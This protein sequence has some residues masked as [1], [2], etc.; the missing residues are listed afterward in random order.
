[1]STKWAFVVFY[2]QAKRLPHMEASLLCDRNG[3]LYTQQ[4]LL[5]RRISVAASQGYG[6]QAQRAWLDV[7]RGGA[8]SAAGRYSQ[9]GV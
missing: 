1:M 6:I 9:G 7:H 2:M 8:S 4:S 3:H 5:E